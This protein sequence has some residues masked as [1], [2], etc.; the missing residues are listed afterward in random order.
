MSER[1]SWLYR[2]SEALKSVLKGLEESREGK[3]IYL[4]SFEKY[5]EDDID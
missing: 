5:A 1:E 2:N 4:G 3:L